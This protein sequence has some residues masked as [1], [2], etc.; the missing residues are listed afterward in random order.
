VLWC[1]DFPAAHQ[2]QSPAQGGQDKAQKGERETGQPQPKNHPGGQALPGQEQDQ[3][4]ARQ[5]I[6]IR[7]AQKHWNVCNKLDDLPPEIVPLRMLVRVVEKGKV[8]G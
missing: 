7:V 8:P 1:L 6:E 4:P 3:V 5:P 2:G